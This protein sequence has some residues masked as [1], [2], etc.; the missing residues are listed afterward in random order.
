MGKGSNRHQ[1][2]TDLTSS[3]E[4]LP[5]PHPAA[6]SQLVSIVNPRTEAHPNFSVRTELC[7][8]ANR[9]YYGITVSAL[10]DYSGHFGTRLAGELAVWLPV[11]RP[12][13]CS[14][15]PYYGF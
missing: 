1:L 13:P 15:R 5:S 2:L 12:N 3:A 7:P 14:P 10:A 6:A 8:A 9:K 4:T 11:H